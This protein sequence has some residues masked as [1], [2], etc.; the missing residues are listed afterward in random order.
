MFL[1]GLSIRAKFKLTELGVIK[2]QADD[3]GAWAQGSE[4]PSAGGNA[5]SPNVL[6]YTISIIS[7]DGIFLNVIVDSCQG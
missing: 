1:V 2:L 7:R 4:T 6:A 5:L 3:D